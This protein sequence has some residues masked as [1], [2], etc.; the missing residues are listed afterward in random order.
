MTEKTYRNFVAAE[1]VA[2]PRAELLRREDIMRTVEGV[3]DTYNTQQRAVIQSLQGETVSGRG[4]LSDADQVRERRKTSALY[5][6]TY[7][8]VAG[9]TIAGLAYLAT[10]AGLSGAVALAG[11][12]AGTGG[13]TLYLAW[14]RHG[15]EFA[16]SPEG[17]ARQL[18]DAHWSL[19]EYEAETRRLALRWEH[20][21]EARRQRAAEQA[22]EHGRQLAALRVEELNARQRAIEAQ[23]SGAIEPLQAPKT[24]H[25]VQSIESATETPQGAAT[26]QQAL[27]EWVAG[28]YVPGA[29]TEEGVIK[30]RVPWAARS[31]WVESDKAAAKRACCELRPKLIVPSDGGRW[32]LRVEAFPDAE[33]ALRLLSARL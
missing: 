23:R 1:P 28:L 24:H 18:V 13:L 16:H 17:I 25:E 33:Q 2:T 32:R 15:D 26:W 4:F 8:T 12:M 9:I 30:C 21:A 14:R 20:Q 6:A 3:I 19:S 29:I 11:W 7:G 5:L 31:P 10:L 22:A 27:L